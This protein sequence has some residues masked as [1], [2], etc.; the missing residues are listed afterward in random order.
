L[1][2]VELQAQVLLMGKTETIPSL[3]QLLQRGVVLAQT[4]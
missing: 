1:V 3:V 2:L 4:M